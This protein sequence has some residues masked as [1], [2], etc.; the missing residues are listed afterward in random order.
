MADDKPETATP[1]RET[2]W[3]MDAKGRRIEVSPLNALE[4]Y[5]LAKAL[6][7]ISSEAAE[8]MAF[9]AAAVRKVDTKLFALPKTETDVEFLIQTLGF[10]GIAAAGLALAKIGKSEEDIKKE[11]EAAKNS[12]GGPS[13]NSGSPQ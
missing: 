12:A 6:G 13:S 2:A 1:A 9:V 11:A 10:E 3:H 8:D 4:Y 7:T 5:R